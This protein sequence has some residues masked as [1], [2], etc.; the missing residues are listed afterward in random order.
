MRQRLVFL[1]IFA[2]AECSMSAGCSGC[3]G[4]GN[5]D[6][7]GSADADAD[8]DADGD[9]DTDADTD[10][11][12]ADPGDIFDWQPLPE[13]Y[14]CGPGCRQL[15]FET[16]N[17]VM[18]W[19]TDGRYLSC[20]LD[21][22]PEIQA[23]LVD[24]QNNC[25]TY[26]SHPKYDNPRWLYSDVCDGKVAFGAR[27][28]DSSIH[29]HTIAYFDIANT[30][31]CVVQEMEQDPESEELYYKELSLSGSNMVYETMHLG[32]DDGQLFR[33]AISN[34]QTAPITDN[35]IMLAK[36]RTNGEYAVW[37][38]L[39]DQLNIEIFAHRISTST[40]WNL[41]D[42]LSDQ[43]SPQMDGTRVVWTDLRNGDGEYWGSYENADIYMYD[44][45]NDSLTRITDGEWV[46]YRPDIS[47]DR[48]VWQDY[49]ACDQPNNVEDFSQVDIWMH[50]LATGEDHQITTLDGAETGPLIAGGKVFFFKRVPNEPLFAL[51]SQDLD[52]LG[53]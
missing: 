14:D 40:T 27:H 47:G 3:G 20:T 37:E 38:D 33:Y 13:G 7:D 48:I 19:S 2:A 24:T 18:G 46:K 1:A 28:T 53:L 16:V 5:D 36:T 26:L 49:R 17:S 44:F 29:K 45:A 39:T 42:H 35:G 31:A 23:I 43:F 21:P 52:V 10:D 51:F 12:C 25:W 6:A 34:S 50:D 11:N 9:A 4:A 30:T 8:T 32:G 22:N 15:T 41:T